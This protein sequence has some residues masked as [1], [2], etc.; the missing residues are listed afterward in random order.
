MRDFWNETERA[1]WAA[2]FAL[3]HAGAGDAEEKADQCLEA[4][5]ALKRIPAAE[6]Y[7][8]LDDH[9]TLS[10]GPA[11]NMPGPTS[12]V[13]IPGPSCIGPHLRKP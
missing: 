1:V 3:A 9:L 11:L 13:P 4:Y 5:R 10:R 7:R 6:P 12:S 2:A 8:S